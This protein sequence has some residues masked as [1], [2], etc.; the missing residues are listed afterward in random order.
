MQLQ[1]S[2][3]QIQME[4]LFIRYPKRTVLPY[5]CEINYMYHVAAALISKTFGSCPKFSVPPEGQTR[6]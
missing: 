5:I 3:Q 1:Q 6:T 2:E 4:P